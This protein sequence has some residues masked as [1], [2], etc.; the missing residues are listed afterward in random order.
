[1]RLN[2]YEMMWIIRRLPKPRL[3]AAPKVVS[4]RMAAGMNVIM[5]KLNKRDFVPDE[6]YIPIQAGP[7]PSEDGLWENFNPK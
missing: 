7:F 5:N 1:M 3:R 2:L 4:E 6:L